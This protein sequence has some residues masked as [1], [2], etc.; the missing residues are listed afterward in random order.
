MA[1]EYQYYRKTFTIKIIKLPYFY[2]F[3][4]IFKFSRLMVISSACFSVFEQCCCFLS[5]GQ[6]KKKMFSKSD[7]KKPTKLD[8]NGWSLLAEKN[9]WVS[10]S[11][12][13]STSP[14]SQW[15]ILNINGVLG[16][17]IFDVW[18]L[19]ISVSNSILSST[20]F[21]FLREENIL[22]HP[23]IITSW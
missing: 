2:Y 20:L 21:F 13:S 8:E 12:K 22:D 7:L 11:L 5:I 4:S 14:Q 15:T 18:N 6:S 23:P 3:L 16:C 19:F 10:P 17:M 1:I 9:G